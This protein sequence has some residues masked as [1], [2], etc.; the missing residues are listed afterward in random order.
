MDTAVTELECF[1]A[2]QKQ[3][4]YAGSHR[5][6]G[7]FEEIKRQK[8]LVENVQK[9]Y[10]DLVAE[11]ERIQRLLEEHK[12]QAHIQEKIDSQ[13]RAL[14][15]SKIQTQIQEEI[16]ENNR[17]FELSNSAADQ[18]DNVQEQITDAIPKDPATDMDVDSHLDS[19]CLEAYLTKDDMVVDKAMLVQDKYSEFPNSSDQPLTADN[20]ITSGF[21]VQIL[22]VPVQEV[23]E[24]GGSAPNLCGTEEMHMTSDSVMDQMPA[25]IG[26][27]LKVYIK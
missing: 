18:V 25:T 13:N 6:N 23:A 8:K 14:E 24:N 12:R 17:A 20:D 3:E 27:S 2:L 19:T 22:N 16:A 15:E 7:L 11:K 5:I 26:D 21:V 9:R 4:H 10:G 1:Q